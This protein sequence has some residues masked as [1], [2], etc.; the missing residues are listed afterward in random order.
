[1][2]EYLGKRCF[3]LVNGFRKGEKPAWCSGIG[4]LVRQ[5]REDDSSRSLLAH[6]RKKVKT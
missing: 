3:F 6:Q 4:K 2:R 1:M 5:W